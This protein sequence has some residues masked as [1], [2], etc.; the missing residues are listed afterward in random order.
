M[1]SKFLLTILLSLLIF[2]CDK[3]KTGSNEL[4]KSIEAPKA[5]KT[6]K[7]LVMHDDTRIDNYFWM[8]L[9]DEQ[10]NAAEPD[11]QTQDVLDYLKAE[12]DYTNAALKHTEEF[13]NKLFDEIVGRIKKDDSSVPYDYND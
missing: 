11:A 9:T 1:S 3:D 4:Y 7:E 5:K 8:R 2:T 12:N 13:Q 6:E 10:K